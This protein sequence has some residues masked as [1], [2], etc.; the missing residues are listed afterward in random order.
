[1]TKKL[2]FGLT[3]LASIASVVVSDTCR[4][5]QDT[6]AIELDHPLSTDYLTENFE[7]WS[8][9]CSALKPS[10]ILSPTTAEEVST[11]VKT[12]RANG[13][14]EK[15]AIKSGGHSPN[16]YFASI[17]GSPLISTRKLN[18]VNLD[19]ASQTVRVGPGNRWVDVAKALDGSGYT[20]VGGR[21]GDVGVGGLMLYGGLSFL[22]AQNGWA[23]SNVLEYEVVLANGTIA[24]ASKDHNKDLFD[25]MHGGGN[26]FGIVTSFLLQAYP[27]DNEIWAGYFIF[28][29]DKQSQILAAIRDFTEN[30]DDHP[31]AA[32]IST[33]VM[34]LDLVEAWLMFVFYDGQ[35]PGDAFKQ[36]LDIG[37]IANTAKKQSYASYLEANNFAA[38]RGFSY[39]MGTETTP[40]PAKTDV[41][42]LDSYINFW[43]KTAKT[44]F[45]TA[46]IIASIAYQPVPKRQLRIAKEKGGDLLDMDENYDYIVFEMNLSYINLPFDWDD[47]RVQ[48]AMKTLYTGQKALID[49]FIKNGSL[50]SI[51]HLPLFANDGNQ[52]Q[53]YW[54]RIKPEK[55]A[56]AKKVQELVDPDNFF[57]S[58]TGSWK[59]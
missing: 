20:P 18:E 36:F 23:M 10:C 30:Y 24:K 48:D 12:L 51:P 49:G 42:V 15:F 6:T 11:I 54:G 4:T 52:G 29:P 7:Y 25:A 31:K 44:L 47:K 56:F 26:N 46:G 41:Y 9:A 43:R 32:I 17:D 28:T 16:K 27:I 45:A 33:T 13:N 58:R 3:A 21:I 14:T 19:A 37:P 40:L 39:E 59:V 5:I 34:P 2:I 57:R 50:P 8:T 38:I 53:D 55:R 1:M 22:S 35:D